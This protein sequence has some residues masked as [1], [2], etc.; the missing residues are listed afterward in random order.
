MHE[1]RASRPCPA[2][3]QVDVRGDAVTLSCVRLGPAIRAVIARYPDARDFEIS[4]AGL[5]EAFLELTAD[6]D[7]ESDQTAGAIA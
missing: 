2:S 5:E 1:R 6:R 3:H 4:G 7:D